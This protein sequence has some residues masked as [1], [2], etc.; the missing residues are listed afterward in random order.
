MPQTV[1]DLLTQVPGVYLWRGGFIGRPEPVNYQ[2]RGASSA[3]YYLDGLPY[4]AAGWTASPWT[5]RSS[6]SASS[7]ASR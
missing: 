6:P 7:S 3:E 1:G 5:P 2:A 4:V